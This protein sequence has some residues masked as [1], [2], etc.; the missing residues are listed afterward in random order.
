MSIV[1]QKQ[2]SPVYPASMKIGEY[3]VALSSEL[4]QSLKEIREE[5]A[6]LFLVKLIEVLGLNRHL[7]EMLEEEIEKE[8]AQET[9]VDGLREQIRAFQVPAT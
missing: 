3:T 1:M 9:L 5:E 4:L 8:E 7:R 6:A 2:H